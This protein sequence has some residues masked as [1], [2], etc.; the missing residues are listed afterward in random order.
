MTIHNA[1]LTAKE[2]QNSFQMIF[3]ELI[4]LLKLLVMLSL[5]TI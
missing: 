5:K 3:L 4:S 2:F 1:L